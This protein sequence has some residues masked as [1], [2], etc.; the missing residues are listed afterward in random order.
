MPKVRLGI[1]LGGTRIK[2]GLVDE[3]D[4]VLH[5]S[6]IETMAHKGAACVVERIAMH[7]ETLLETNHLTKADILSVGIGSPG[8]IDSGRGVVVYS[9][10][11]AWKDVAVVE[12]LKKRIG[13]EVKIDNDANAAALGEVK[14]GSGKG[15]DSVVL[16]TLGTGVGSGIIID[17]KIF[18]GTHGA[19]AELGHMIVAADGNLCTCGQR[20]CLEAYASATALIAQTKDALRKSPKSKLSMLVADWQAKGQEIDYCKMIFENC[21]KEDLAKQVME[22]YAHS[23]VVGL[24][25][26]ANIFRPQAILIGGGI[27]AQ[28]ENLRKRINQEFEKGVFGG[29]IGPRVELRIATLKNDAGFMG[30]ACL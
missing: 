25:N 29:A 18:S 17:G 28:G 3:A 5:T 20:G 23:L 22:S 1:D 12:M 24:V 2:G 19:G 15:L 7:I 26:I 30:A 8:I 13:M 21:D 9:N 16:V 10:N 6:S 14:F 4:K 27:S 11:L